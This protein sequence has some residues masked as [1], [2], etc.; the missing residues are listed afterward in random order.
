MSNNFD[1]IVTLSNFYNDLIFKEVKFPSN[2]LLAIPNPIIFDINSEKCIKSNEIIYVGRIDLNQKRLDLL[3]YIWQKVSINNPSWKLKIVGSGDDLSILKQIISK[4]KIDQVE[5]LGSQNPIEHYRKAK[6][7]CLTSSFEG[8]PLVIHEA[9]SNFVVPIVFN[10]FSSS[11]EMIENSNNGFIINE[12]D[13]DGYILHLNLLMNDN[14]LFEE[15]SHN[16][17]INVRKYNINTIGGKW[18]SLLN[19]FK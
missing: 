10:T 5:I 15:M 7:L 6:I 9:Q 12:E 18:I 16:A 11:Y 1:K 4:N 17:F 14:Y 3:I 19:D 8:W 13:I 2:K